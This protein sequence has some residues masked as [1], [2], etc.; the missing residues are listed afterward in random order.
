MTTRGDDDGRATTGRI[1]R[2]NGPL[3]EVEAMRRV[4]MREV[5]ELGALR[6]PA[7]VVSVAGDLVTAQAYEYLGGVRVGDPA[8]G[9]GRPLSAPLGPGLLGGIFDGL[10]RP[11]TGAAEWLVPGA[12]GARTP[13]G[14][15]AFRP[16]VRSGDA[17]AEGMALGVL[18]SP[19][20]VEHRVLVPP[21]LSGRIDWI[22]AAGELAAAAAVARVG[23]REI[24]LTQ[25]WP[26]RSRP[27]PSRARLGASA[28]LLT[29]QRA[30]ELFF[31]IAKGDTAAVPGG[32]GTGKT[33]LLQQI[34]KWSDADVIVFVGCGERGNEL[35]DAMM[36]LAELRDPTTGRSL[37]ERTIVI[38]NTS[39]MPVMAREASIYTGM[40][41][42][43]FYRD[44][45]Y[46]V[47]L[48]ADST[49]RWAEALR[50]FSS[51]SGELPA[52]EG[53][54]ARLASAIAAFYE[55][56]G[57][58]TTLG[59]ANGSVTVIG[60]VSP[61]GGDMTEPVTAQ[62]E[63]FIRCLWSLD[64]DLAYAR[65]YPAVT[66]R[67]SFSRDVETIG[68]WHASQGRP[69][70][71]RN[72]A[73]AVGLLAEADRLASV[74]E[75]VGLGALPARER[76]VLL[77]GR[78]LREG[79]LQQNALSPN[80]ASCAPAKQSALLELVLAVHDRSLRLV[81]G[82]LSAAA[83]EERDLSAL[84]RARDEVGADDAAGVARIREQILAT[85]ESEPERS[86]NP[87]E[88]HRHRADSGRVR[89]RAE[90]QRPPRDR[91]RRRR[92][93]RLGRVRR[94]SASE[95][96]G[97][98]RPRPR[99][100]PRPRGR[101]VAA[102]DDRDRPRHGARQLRRASAGDPGRRR[103]AGPRVER[104]GRAARRWPADAGADDASRQRRADQSDRARRPA[105][106]HPDGDLDRRCAD[107]R[108][109]AGKSC[110]SSRRPDSRISSWP[111]SSPPKPTPPASPSGSSSRRWDSRTR[112]RRRSATCLR[113]ARPRA[114]SRSSSI[115]RTI[116]S[117]N[118]F[119][120]RA[121]HS[122]SRS[123]LRSNAAS[124]CSSCW[125]T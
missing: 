81:E 93:G 59:G 75:L 14:S 60:A 100:P 8:V 105:R 89:R 48:L 53:F 82:G 41:V 42:A 33:M 67:L 80:D 114:T 39:N 20:R 90:R 1:V 12:L 74:V 26:I 30:L 51:R 2:V 102:R 107:E 28:P 83:I 95:R 96:R 23:D 71:A 69:E 50:E 43:E 101:A 109:C 64:R 35:A 115:L 17:A 72:R 25:W 98:T 16:T 91:R 78:W 21:G 97:A 85:L 49:S 70:W 55:R 68:A 34:L 38:A 19:D 104:D 40:T 18:A 57:R 3:V 111:P 4:A 123:T 29:G 121:S 6:I 92:R 94:R 88:S 36:D 32:F 65:H 87:R 22:A 52:E 66:W 61:P 116:R 45:G 46:D 76:M 73:R 106:P 15:F 63:R 99:D 120:L 108:S 118:A 124:T 54:P 47:L 24:A 125:P 11:L 7:E 113:A 10:L 103:V 9:L 122:R 79:V 44:M 37:L 110:R 117:S 62:T 86:A 56:A 84:S 13:P 112:T 58:V 77:A 5:I 119:S 27:R 31:P